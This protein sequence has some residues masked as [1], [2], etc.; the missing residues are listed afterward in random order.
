VRKSEA[1]TEARMGLLAPVLHGGERTYILLIL[2]DNIG[3]S[4][5]KA[6]GFLE[7]AKTE[8]LKAFENRG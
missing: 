2:K 5:S 6:R 7:V 4:H 1:E 3:S 8:K